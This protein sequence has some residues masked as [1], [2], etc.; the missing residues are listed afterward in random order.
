MLAQAMPPTSPCRQAERGQLR[1]DG[2]AVVEIDIRASH[3]HIVYALRGQSLAQH[4]REFDERATSRRSTR[5]G[6][7][8]AASRSEDLGHH[9]AGR[10]ESHPKKVAD[11]EAVKDLKE[12][13]H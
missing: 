5:T 10:R 6:R 2:E 4:V 8:P 12:D 11:K 13:R 1:L 3:L 9:H 7:R